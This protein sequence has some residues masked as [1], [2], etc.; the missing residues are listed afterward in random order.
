MAA[1][2]LIPLRYYR[3][4]INHLTFI[5]DNADTAAL[6]LTALKGICVRSANSSSADPAL[7]RAEF[8]RV[9]LETMDR[10]PRD[11]RAARIFF[12]Y[13]D[14]EISS[15]DRSINS[16]ADNFLLEFALRQLP[17][18]VEADPELS[19]KAAPFIRSREEARRL[20]SAYRAGSLSSTENFQ[21][22]PASIPHALELS[23]ISEEQAVEELF[24][25]SLIDSDLIS[26]VSRFMIS[27]NGK[28]LFMQKLLSFSGIITADSD[29]DGIPESR[30][31]YYD[32]ALREFYLDEDQD[33]VNDLYIMCINGIPQ[34]AFQTPYS[35]LN[36]YGFLEN[37]GKRTLIQWEQYPYVR[38]VEI[39]K[40]VYI[41]RPM[42][43]RYA[44]V[45]FEELAGSETLAGLFFPRPDALW[46]LLGHNEL[47][48]HALQIQR[49]SRE[50]EGAVEWID[51]EL[52][53]PWRA[54]EYINGQPIAIT[55]FS[56]GQPVLQWVDLDRDS[57]METLRRFRITE[58]FDDASRLFC[59]D[60]RK[61]IE[62]SMSDW[63]GD[64]LFEYAEE[65]LPDGTI[66]YSWDMD[67]SG[68]RNYSERKAGTNTH[69]TE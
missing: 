38:R 34:W 27:D 35:D 31:L 65:Y 12:E 32:G 6:K 39:D 62:I 57:R 14:S 8:R 7:D 24:K 20:L 46:M 33:G 21:P 54:T 47:V 52:G 10:Y 45:H 9:T 63:D 58:R 23:L 26:A 43:F 29:K 2:Y 68:I 5:P 28:N 48:L 60:Y 49:P 16:D 19:W 50:F 56:D 40:I 1:Q 42:E 59:L 3:E 25:L 18:L 53:L 22:H 66:I 41:L 4:A 30:A 13:A 37:S 67:G 51:L 11:P 44:P 69:D 17:L 36:G 61:D 55:E 64:G 15:E